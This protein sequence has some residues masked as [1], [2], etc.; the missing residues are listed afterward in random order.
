MEKRLSGCPTDRAQFEVFLISRIFEMLDAMIASAL[1]KIIRN[2][3]F[4]E[5]VSLE[6]QKGREEVRRFPEFQA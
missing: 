4:K 3:S 2:S 6:E 5:K 1:N